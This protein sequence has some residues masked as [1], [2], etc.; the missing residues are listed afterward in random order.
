MNIEKKLLLFNKIERILAILGICL[1]ASLCYYNLGISMAIG[2]LSSVVLIRNLFT[3]VSLTDNI[4]EKPDSL[5][6]TKMYEKPFLQWAKTYLKEE[7]NV[8]KKKYNL[9][10]MLIWLDHKKLTKYHLKNVLKEDYQ[11]VEQAVKEIVD[12]NTSKYN[13]LEMLTKLAILTQSSDILKEHYTAEKDYIE[14]AYKPY[15]DLGMLGHEMDNWNSSDVIHSLLIVQE[16]KL[17]KKDLTFLKASIKNKKKNHYSEI[18]EE[19]ILCEDDIENLKVIR[20]FFNKKEYAS[21]DFEFHSTEEQKR[22]PIYIENF[23]R[24]INYSSLS[25]QLK[26][27]PAEIVKINKI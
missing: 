20:E 12:S 24:K 9:L 7:P 26:E 13:I 3:Y 16:Y 6:Y 14:E 19:L 2:A 21:M 17:S 25:Q 22:H 23:D 27:K 5:I 8:I 1:S 4:G 18:Y 15:A 10:F 11:L